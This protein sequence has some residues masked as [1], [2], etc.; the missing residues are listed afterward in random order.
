[1]M[2]RGEGPKQ[3]TQSAPISPEI[4][5]DDPAHGKVRNILS[6]PFRSTS[7]LSAA[8]RKKRKLFPKDKIYVRGLS[9]HRKNLL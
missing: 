2:R 1:M 6:S 4:K 7:S 3:S 8:R 9:S 5:V